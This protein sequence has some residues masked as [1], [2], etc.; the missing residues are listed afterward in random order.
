MTFSHL[1]ILYKRLEEWYVLSNHL[2]GHCESL[3]HLF[4]G[5]D[6]NFIEVNNANNS[7]LLINIHTYLFS[8]DLDLNS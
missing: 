4:F 5:Y 8:I 3:F 2:C 1:A 7:A 6:A